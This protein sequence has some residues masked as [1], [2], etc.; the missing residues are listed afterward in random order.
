MGPDRALMEGAVRHLASFERASASPGE[1]AAAEW[2]AGALEDL[3]LQ[4]VLEEGRAHGGFWWPLGLLNAV[5]VAAAFLRPRWL[6]RALAAVA[7][8]A[9]ADDLDHRSRWFRRAFLPQRPTYNVHAVA[10]DASAARTVLVVAHHDAAHGGRIFDTTLLATI[11]RRWPA[12]YDRFT[13]WPPL[14]W[15]V[16]AAPVLVAA[17]HRKHALRAGLGTM[18]AM[19]DIARSPVAPGANDNLAAVGALLALARRL[20]DDPVEGLRVVLLSTG[21]EESNSEGMQEYGRAHFAALPRETTDVIALECLGS[22]TVTIAESEGFLVPHH[23]DAALKDLAT[24]CAA[25]AGVPVRRGLHIVFASD[26]QIA[27]HAGYRAMTLAASDELKL[28][29]NYHKPTDTP[30][31]LDLDCLDGAVDVLEG[32]VRALAAQ[33]RS[34]SERATATAS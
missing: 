33:S 31:N 20:R 25:D 1:R 24:A 4:P 13:R 18:L 23:Y 28:P 3:G 6:G 5:A 29:A 11:H 27:L 9:M 22:G 16:I 34:S 17:G 10:G 26:A 30:E 19:A 8:V 32:T 2:I 14:M 12:L 15:L 7:A 21:S